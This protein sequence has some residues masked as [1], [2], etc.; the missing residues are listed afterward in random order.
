MTTQQFGAAEVYVTTKDILDPADKVEVNWSCRGAVNTAQAAQ[1]MRDM[2]SAVDWAH[3]KEVE[4]A[5][6][7]A[8]RNEPE[9]FQSDSP[10]V[11]LIKRD[12]NAIGHVYR[13]VGD[14]IYPEVVDRLARSIAASVACWLDQEPQRGDD[15]HDEA[16]EDAFGP[17]GQG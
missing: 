8:P 10:L 14:A 6:R 16:V 4:M 9:E 2:K 17:H 5:C 3:R 15:D 12:I 7:L 11:K 13:T 1:F